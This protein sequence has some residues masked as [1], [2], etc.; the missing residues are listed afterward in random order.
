MTTRFPFIYRIDY[1]LKRP[2]SKFRYSLSLFGFD[3]L[4]FPVLDVGYHLL[5]W[6]TKR[7]TCLLKSPKS[8]YTRGYQERTTSLCGQSPE[9]KILT[10]PRI[11]SIRT[12]LQITCLQKK[13]SFQKKSLPVLI[14][15]T[16]WVENVIL[17][18]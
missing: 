3:L 5:N 2:P 12:L 8:G 13:P 1:T 16:P 11:Y 10:P 4:S 15:V 14:L 7:I 9:P 6:L 17:D 18:L